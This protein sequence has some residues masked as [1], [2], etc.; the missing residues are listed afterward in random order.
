M[1]DPHYMATC[2]WKHNEVQAKQDS[3][4]QKHIALIYCCVIEDKGHICNK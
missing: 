4:S 2:M 1:I 3:C